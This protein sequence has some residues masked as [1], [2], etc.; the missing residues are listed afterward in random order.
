MKDKLFQ[1]ID[2]LSKYFYSIV[3]WLVYKHKTNFIAKI[4]RE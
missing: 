4:Q 3:M 1:F 2:K